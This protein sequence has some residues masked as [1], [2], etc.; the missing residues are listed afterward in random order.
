[1]NDIFKF[2]DGKSYVL[3][4][5]DGTFEHE[6]TGAT[7]PFPSVHERLLHNPSEL[8]KQSEHYRQIKH[9]LGDDWLS[10]LTG[11]ERYVDIAIEL[12]YDG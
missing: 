5:V 8:G 11:S 6:V 3:D 2:L 4:S 1:M 7:Y 9:K 12:G 10:D